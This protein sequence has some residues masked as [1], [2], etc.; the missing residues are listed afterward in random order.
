MTD[1][2]LFRRGTILVRR[3]RLATGEATPWHRDPYHR[4]SVVISGDVIEIEFRDG[5]APE[6]V[7]LTPGRAD[8]DEP[9]AR[10]HRAVNIGTETYEE[11]TTFLLDE[12]DAIAQPGE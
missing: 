2:V 7:A 5:G 1:D 3:M 10:I 12:P 6:R 11:V 4:V 8:W 9:L